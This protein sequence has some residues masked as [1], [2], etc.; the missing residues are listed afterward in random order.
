MNLKSRIL[1]EDHYYIMGCSIILNNYY[2]YKIDFRRPFFYDIPDALGI[3]RHYRIMYNGDFIEII[4][5]DK[6]KDITD[7][8]VAELLDNFDNIE[9]LEGEVFHQVVGYLKES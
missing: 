6:A 8:D 1:D 7:A 9:N 5:T 2:G 3:M 4:K